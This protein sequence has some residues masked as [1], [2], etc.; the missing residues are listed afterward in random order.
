VSKFTGP[1]VVNVKKDQMENRQ[2]IRS[3]YFA[4]AITVIGTFA[5][6][7]LALIYFFDLHWTNPGYPITSRFEQGFDVVRT[8]LIATLLSSWAIW[9]GTKVRNEFGMVML[10]TGLGTL[11]SLIIYAILGCRG[12]SGTWIFYDLIFPSEF[13]AE[14]N[15]FTV[16]LEVAP[17][18]SIAASLLLYCSL[19]FF[20]PAD[21][22]RGNFAE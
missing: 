18:T 8:A 9:L 10:C 1:F 22:E 17:V 4:I 15:F 11:V 6:F 12:I 2:K 20:L 5:V 13:F 16:M 7:A 3:R 21:G 14:F 19:R